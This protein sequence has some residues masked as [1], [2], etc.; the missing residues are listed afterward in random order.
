GQQVV[1]APSG[2][3]HVQQDQVGPRG[4]QLVVR[5]LGRAGLLDKVP[6]RLEQPD[7][8]PADVLVVV[9]DENASLTGPGNAAQGASALGSETGKVVPSPTSLTTS[10][11]PPL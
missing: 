1:T 2:Q 9:D 6:H 3:L 10:I 7:D 8:Q 11:E 4:L 5:F